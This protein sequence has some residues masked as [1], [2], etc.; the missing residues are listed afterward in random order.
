MPFIRE[1]SWLIPMQADPQRSC[2][3]GHRGFLGNGHPTI[4]TQPSTGQTPRRSPRHSLWQRRP[5]LHMW[6][7]GNERLLA[8]L[9]LCRHR[10][11][12][13]LRLSMKKKKVSP[14][15]ALA[16]KAAFRFT[17]DWPFLPQTRRGPSSRGTTISRAP[18]ACFALANFTHS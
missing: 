6:A 14:T 18:G 15:M 16:W 9:L 17:S 2:K 8:A 4:L 7:Q 5:I 1:P 13:P 3:D 10:Q 12:L 11:R